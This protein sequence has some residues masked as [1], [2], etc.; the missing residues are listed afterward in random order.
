MSSVNYCYCGDWM[1]SVNYCYCGTVYCES[2]YCYSGDWMSSVNYCYCGDCIS[3]V[4]LLLLWR[5]DVVSQLL[6]M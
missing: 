2:T 6:L 5:L 4:N 3:L 1:S